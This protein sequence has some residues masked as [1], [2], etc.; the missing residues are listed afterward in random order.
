ME[1]GASWYVFPREI[2]AR[3]LSSAR[4]ATQPAAQDLGPSRVR[5]LD[6]GRDCSARRA[7]SPMPTGSSRRRPFTSARSSASFPK[8]PKL[9]YSCTITKARARRTA[10]HPSASVRAGRARRVAE[11]PLR[12]G[13][14]HIPVSLPRCLRSQRGRP[15][16]D[17]RTLGMEPAAVP[18]RPARRFFDWF[19]VRRVSSPDSLFVSDPIHPTRGALRKLVALPSPAPPRLD[20]PA[21]R[22]RL[23]S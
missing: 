12:P 9:L 3:A 22:P 15:A 17:A 19:L 11:L 1:I 10:L 8:A 21:K 16:E 18:T 14:R 7:S 20:R 6:G 2:T 5:D 23:E 13:G 4:A